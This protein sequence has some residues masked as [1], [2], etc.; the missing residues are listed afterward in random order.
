MGELT[1]VRG[2]RRGVLC[3]AE[4]GALVDP[5]RHNGGLDGCDG[6]GFPP[7]V[8][9][10]ALERRRVGRSGFPDDDAG[11]S[12]LRLFR[13]RLAEA[14]GHGARHSR[15]HDGRSGGRHGDRPG[16]F[17][18]GHVRK[19]R[20]KTRLGERRT[21]GR[22]RLLDDD[23]GAE[24]GG[25]GGAG[26]DVGR[27]VGLGEGTRTEDDFGFR[28]GLSAAAG[29]VLVLG[30]G[31]PVAH[32]GVVAACCVRVAD[33]WQLSCLE[34]R[35]GG[36]KRGDLELGVV[37][38]RRAHDRVLL[39]GE[40]VKSSEGVGGVL[41][42]DLRIRVAHQSVPDLD[43]A[44]T[45]ENVNPNGAPV[46]FL[47]AKQVNEGVGF[48]ARRRLTLQASRHPRQR[49]RR[50]TLDPSRRQTR[51]VSPSRSTARRRDLAQKNAGSTRPG[52]T[53]KL[54]SRMRGSMSNRWLRA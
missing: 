8:T 48:K 5:G 3:D 53:S 41:P 43:C 39:A 21:G 54:A 26:H 46:F 12:P 28:V 7:L 31:V 13:N 34:R 36:E 1:H 40:T 49:A 22:G 50:G 30:V 42:G 15:C 17:M 24:G 44:T 51:S 2:R 45:F 47:P 35:R 14:E 37:G 25:T 18:A 38:V 4:S 23:A 6:D 9:G 19:R 29:V 27:V 16:A 20:G 10:H 11:G 33:V 52:R 32:G